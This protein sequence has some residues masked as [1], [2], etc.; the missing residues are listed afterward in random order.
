M[1]ILRQ[2]LEAGIWISG[3]RIAI[4][5]RPAQ[6]YP[7]ALSGFPYAHAS[8]S[9]PQPLTESIL[10]RHLQSYGIFIERGVTLTALTQ[11]EKTVSVQLASA[12]GKSEETHFRY[13]IGC[14]GAHSFVRRAAGIDFEGETMPF[15][16]MLGDVQIDWPLPNGYSF[17]SIYPAANTAPEFFV[18][19][20]LPEPHRYRIS[21]LAPTGLSFPDEGTD[22]GIQSERPAP[23]L[24][25]LQTKADQLLGEP[26]RLS[27]LRWSSLFRISMRLASSYQAGNLFLAGDAAHIHPPTGGQ[28]MN[29]G[30]QDAYN[31]AWKMALVLKGKSPERLLES[32]TA[33]RREEGE[34]VIDRSL[35]A[36]MNTGSAGFKTD[37][38]ADTQ[39]LVSYRTSPW[40]ASFSEEHWP[41]DL[42]PGDRAPDCPGL[43]RPGIGYSF[44]LF[45]L[46]KGTAHVLLIDLRTPTQQSLNELT[47]FVFGLRAEFGK[48]IDLYLRLVIIRP[49][50]GSNESIP[51]ITWVNDPDG[52]FASTYPSPNEASWLIRPDGYISWCGSGYTNPNLVSYLLTLFMPNSLSS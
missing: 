23:E 32:Y 10:T 9:L 1:G 33:E 43:R 17:Q 28:G 38:L 45:D 13:V 30:I 3:R 47:L 25:L 34:N 22:H 18:A 20:P 44:R 12:D 6:D 19:I 40:V 26:A 48:E 31:L 2:A 39:L 4:A 5:G 7:E 27:D 42:L 24:K 37:R 29:T 15:E 52:S 41:S 36:S 21:M 14:D 50:S 51:G 8:L 46:L 49:E 35:R 16:F 11:V